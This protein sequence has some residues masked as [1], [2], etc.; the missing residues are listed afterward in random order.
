M[1]FFL[2]GSKGRRR[3]VMFAG[4]GYVFYKLEQPKGKETDKLAGT[5][6]R[7]RSK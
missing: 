6:G 2:R 1:P 3:E 4:S 5:Q 7:T